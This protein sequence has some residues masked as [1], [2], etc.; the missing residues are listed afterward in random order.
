M[1]P[2]TGYLFSGVTVT[3]INV[4]ETKFV[5]LVGLIYITHIKKNY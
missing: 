1:I 2:D 5:K 3:K 4:L